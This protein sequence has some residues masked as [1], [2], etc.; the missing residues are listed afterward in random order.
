VRF[1]WST[2]VTLFLDQ[3]RRRIVLGVITVNAI[4]LQTL[5]AQRLYS[6][7]SQ[8]VDRDLGFVPAGLAVRTPRGGGHA[9]MA[10]ITQAPPA[11]HTYT[12]TDSASIAPVN[13]ILLRTAP[14]EIIAVGPP[15]SVDYAI[16][17]DAGKAVTLVKHRGATIGTESIPLAVHAQH[18][19]AA[20]IN[21][22]GIKDILLCGKGMTGIATLL[23]SRGGSFRPG[24][25]LLGDISV[26][27]FRVADVNGDGI[28][29]VILNNWLSNQVS[30]FYGISSMVFSEQVVVDL[31]G[32][33]S[34]IDFA[35]TDRRR[36]MALAVTLPAEHKII[37]LHGRP[38]GD[39][40]L[41]QTLTVPAQ[42]SGAIFAMVD[43]DPYPDIV[44]ATDRGMAISIGRGPM[45]YLP[46]GLLG[47]GANGRG[48]AIVD[49]DGDR[50][51]DLVVAERE[52]QRLV[53]FSN[54]NHAGRT[55]WPATYA[56]GSKPTGVAVGDINGDALPDIAVAN[57]NSSSISV[58]LNRGKGLFFGQ[59]TL[60]VSEQPTAI[61]IAASPGGEVP[62]LVSSHTGSDQ[63]GVVTLDFMSRRA[64]SFSVPTGPRPS[65]LRAWQQPG[66]LTVLV[67]N[68][69][70]DGG[71]VSLSLFE[72]I[73]GRQFLERS[74][75]TNIPEQLLA[76]TADRQRD[77]SSYSVVFARADKS[78]G[79]STVS[80]AIADPSFFVQTVVPA[81][82]F[83]DSTES[84]RSLIPA[85]LTPEGTHGM[86]VVLGKPAYALLLAYNSAEG[87]QAQATNW[88]YNVSVADDN[89]I[90]VSDVDGDGFPDITIR[91]LATETIE[92]IFGG[93]NGFSRRRPICSARGVRG[94]AVA[95]LTTSGLPDLI[96]TRADEATVSLQFSPF[97]TK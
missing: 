28:Q 97:G 12:F 70:K 5:Y 52:T 13:S 77:S 62:D 79:T 50:K 58:L 35:W 51:A 56:V 44:A 17:T 3:H 4:W 40:R 60:W 23:G 88:V 54:A 91:N 33:P 85:R 82:S 69:D 34:S 42:P 41:D 2:S 61:T 19:V 71:A 93:K 43:E 20:D 16:L 96:L 39:V 72:Q 47:P 81:F 29:D 80:Y 30:M 38:D 15:G 90:V 68:Q 21:S 6:T 14:E 66:T 87:T 53:C 64:S 45:E 92:T 36:R 89:D 86:V 55:Q 18:L 25:E 10:V 31:P 27:D 94:I 48:F 8:A 73:S 26:S 59:Q 78:T 83:Q 84:T 67:R 76:V 7:F 95:P 1:S 32:E 46:P 57:A 74:L 63:I 9:E 24:P 11:L 75:R 65:V 49:L 37:I 22:D